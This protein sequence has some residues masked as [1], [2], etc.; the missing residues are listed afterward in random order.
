MVSL[1]LKYCN[2]KNATPKQNEP[3]DGHFW[4]LRFSK[5][6]RDMGLPKKDTELPFSIDFSKKVPKK[7]MELPFSK[8][9]NRHL[10]K[11]IMLLQN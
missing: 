9:S 1:I 5:V 2:S 8:N 4:F 11:R 6:P 7:D 3:V 10:E